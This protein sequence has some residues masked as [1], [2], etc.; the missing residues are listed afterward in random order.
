MVKNKSKEYN[1]TLHENQI[2][3]FINNTGDVTIGHS[4]LCFL[5]Q[6]EQLTITHEQDTTEKILEHGWG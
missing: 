4:W 3:I 1:R 6:E 2:S 5:L